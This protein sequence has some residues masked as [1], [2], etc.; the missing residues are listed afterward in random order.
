VCAVLAVAAAVLG[1][2]DVVAP[3]AV[4]GGLGGI[5]MLATALVCLARR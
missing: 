4:A 1:V 5:A 3:N 2:A